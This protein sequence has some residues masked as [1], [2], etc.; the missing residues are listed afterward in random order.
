VSQ[1]DQKLY[2]VMM[3]SRQHL[4]A[5]IHTRHANYNMQ[6]EGLLDQDLQ[7]IVDFAKQ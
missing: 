2:Q 1:E 4:Q 3:G 6:R 5:K 7:A